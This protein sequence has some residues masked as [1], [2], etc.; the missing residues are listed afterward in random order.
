[1]RLEHGPGLGQELELVVILLAEIVF[2]PAAADG[3][4]RGFR[5]LQQRRNFLL[6]LDRQREAPSNTAAGTAVV[7]YLQ[8]YQAIGKRFGLTPANW[9]KLRVPPVNDPDGDATT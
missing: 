1:M 8:E 5:F 4:F 3:M 6:P 9:Q 2:L 7:R